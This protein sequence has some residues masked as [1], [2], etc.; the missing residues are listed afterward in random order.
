MEKLQEEIHA[1][2]NLLDYFQDFELQVVLRE[3]FYMPAFLQLGNITSPK[4]ICHY[5][6]LPL[7][8]ILERL[9]RIYASLPSF[10]GAKS[11]QDLSQN[12]DVTY[13]DLIELM[14]PGFDKNAFVERGIENQAHL[15]IF[16]KN[17]SEVFSAAVYLSEEGVQVE[18][19]FVIE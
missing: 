14:K 18:G 1:E 4:D 2:S 17:A 9:H 19:Y 16:G 3:A 8:Q 10:L 15:V 5:R 11:K 12:G 13:M 7:N 6:S